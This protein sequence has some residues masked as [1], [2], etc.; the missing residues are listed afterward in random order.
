MDLSKLSEEQFRI[1]GQVLKATKKAGLNPDFVMPMVMHESGFNQNIVSPK[2]AV[3][4]FQLTPDRAKSLGVDPKVEEQNIDGGLRFIKQLAENKKIN[5]DPDKIIAAYNAGPDT[6]FV[7]T[8]NVKDLP[9]ETL[10]HLAKVEKTAGGSIP[11]PF[12]VQTEATSDQTKQPEPKPIP[13]AIPAADLKSKLIMGGAGAMSGAALGTPV[14]GGMVLKK[15]GNTISGLQNA[16]EQLNASTAPATSAA[17]STPVGGGMSVADEQASRILRG[18]TGDAGTTGRA[19]MVGFNTETS[20][21]AAAKNQAQKVIDVLRQSGQVAQDAPEFFAQQPGL[22][23]SPHGVVYPRS[24]PAPTV[25]PRGP[26]GEI[27]G[28]RPPAPRVSGLDAAKSLFMDMM[29]T[30]KEMTS[31]VPDLGGLA[32]RTGEMMRRL[33]IVSGPLAGFALGAEFPE[34][35]TGLR[36]KNPD[37][38]DVGLT[39]AGM[40]GTLGSF[41]PAAPLAA[42]VSIGAPIAREIRRQNREIER[43]PSAYTETLQNALSNT[44]PMGSPLPMQ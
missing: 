3:G 22:T 7:I 20:Q 44:D 11:S 15:M 38:T 24:T 8:R 2:G 6:K 16:I 34:L 42:P 25:G 4:I 1:Y 39:A 35:E 33:P 26:L 29:R 37:Y 43:N 31:V 27:G 19:R 10:N 23:S 5:G 13:D 14:Q 12:V 30:G 41:T 36:A 18:T 28:V 21:S 40:L 32:T 17:P 9:D